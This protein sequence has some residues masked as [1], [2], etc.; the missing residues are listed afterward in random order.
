MSEQSRLT[1][2]VR[3]GDNDYLLAFGVELNVVGN[4]V[5]AKRKLCF[6]NGMSALAY[7]Q[8]VAIFYH[9]AYIAV[10]FGGL[11]ETKQTVEPCH[12]VGIDLYLGDKLLRS[13]N[14]FVEKTFF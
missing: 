10:L 8:H 13:R 14:Q 1:S 7:V 5:F 11:G 12:N 9:G 3:T 2:H 4:V 6:D